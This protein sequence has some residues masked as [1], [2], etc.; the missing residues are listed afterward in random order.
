MGV[1]M[2]KHQSP[3]DTAQLSPTSSAQSIPANLRDRLSPVVMEIYSAGDFHRVDM[4]TI[5]RDAGMSFRT[6]YRYFGDKE[7]LLFWFIKHW[8]EG[9]YPVALKPLD[10]NGDLK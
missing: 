7:T 5:A 10:G 1:V 9:L 2:P 4:R 3:A 8:L 6:I